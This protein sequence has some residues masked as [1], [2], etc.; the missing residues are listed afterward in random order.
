MK[1]YLT[2]PLTKDKASSL[3]AGDS[4]FLTGT[5][6]TARDAAHKRLIAMLDAGLPLPF[7]LRDAAIYYVGPTPA[8]DGMALGSA[9]PTTSV[10]CDPYTPQL[11]ENGVTVMIG[12]GKRS[13]EVKK[14]IQANKSVYLAA[15]G[16]AGA[17]L[18]QCIK[19]AEVIAFE[20]LGTEAIRKLYVENF[21][22]VVINDCHGG[23][24]YES[25]R[26]IY[27]KQNK[28]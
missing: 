25:A 7:S 9:G 2:L 23:D 19:S 26:E 18:A 15:T 21:P 5:L 4:V 1:K 6:Y 24:Y 27:L 17:L 12:K 11:L 10:R 3:C 22:A 14:A 20:D 13:A 16:G 28:I 8:L